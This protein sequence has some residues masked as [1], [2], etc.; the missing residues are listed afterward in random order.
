MEALAFSRLKCSSRGSGL[1]VPS[2]LGKDEL[3]RSSYTRVQNPYQIVTLLRVRR[4]AAG[5][6]NTRRGFASAYYRV[7]TR[8]H[9]NP[10]ILLQ[11]QE[12]LQ[13]H[14][15]RSAPHQ[16]SLSYR[17][18]EGLENRRRAKR[19]CLKAPNVF[20]TLREVETSISKP[21]ILP[22][23]ILSLTKLFIRSGLRWRPVLK[24]EDGTALFWIPLR[25]TGVT[26]INGHHFAWNCCVL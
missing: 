21:R 5:R 19:A 7:L 2:P 6:K 1:G 14:S 23:T 4:A 8:V 26:T 9:T 18:V 17:V 12:P 24:H 25:S 11:D 10:E 13:A 20:R 15:A 22:R 3:Q 16:T